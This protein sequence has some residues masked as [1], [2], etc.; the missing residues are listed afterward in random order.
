MHHTLLSLDSTVIKATTMFEAFPRIPLYWREVQGHYRQL[1]FIIGHGSPT[2]MAW[3]MYT[4][5]CYTWCM[6][7]VAHTKL[8][9]L[10][11]HSQ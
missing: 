6:L 11:G 10:Q 4:T 7:C 5:A 8:G 2:Q 9:T 1:R 3:Y